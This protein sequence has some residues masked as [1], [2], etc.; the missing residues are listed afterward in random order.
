MT[1]KEKQEILDEG[2]VLFS[3]PID[4]NMDGEMESN[5]SQQKLVEHGNKFYLVQVSFGEEKPG[6]ASEVKPQDLDEDDQ[7][8][9]AINNYKKGL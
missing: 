4:T 2:T 6:F 1:N 8:V 5:G 3:Q 7:I 9:I